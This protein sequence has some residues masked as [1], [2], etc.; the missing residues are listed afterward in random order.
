MIISIII[1]IYNRIHI[2]QTGLN[3]LH[4]SLNHHLDNYDGKLIFKIIVIDDASPDNSGLHISKKYPDIDVVFSP[5]NL[6]WSGCINL[7]VKFGLEKNNSDYFLLWNDD[8][9]PDKSYFSKLALFIEKHHP[10]KFICGSAIYFD[11]N[12]NKLWSAG[13]YFSKWTGNKYTIRKIENDESLIDCH[14]QPGMGTLV[15]AYVITSLNIWWDEKRY[16]QYYG[17]S[18]FNLRSL[19]RNI[20]IYTNLDLKI[21]NRTE[22]TGDASH[23]NLKDFWKSLFSMRSFYELKRNMMFYS[24]HGVIP[25]VYIGMLKKYIVYLGRVLKFFYKNTIKSVK[26]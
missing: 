14:W 15:P 1:P 4:K 18:D 23:P 26:F 21:Y 20:G 22:I 12:K 17:D 25:L 13:G 6:W 9:Y 19:K 11:S 16:P 8:I 3:D 7:G 10:V 2:S 5:G 24:Q